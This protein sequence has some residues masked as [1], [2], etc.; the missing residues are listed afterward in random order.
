M[1]WVDKAHQRNKIDKMI[2]EAMNSPKYKKARKKDIEQAALRGL[3]QFCFIALLWLEMNFRCKREGIIKFLTFTKKTVE[4]IG[5][6][7]DFLKASNKYYIE[8]YDIDVMRFLGM[9]FEEDENI[10][11]N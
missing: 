8:K 9:A 5:R 7:V 4:E 11:K 1:S 6:D 2:R 3:A 10:E